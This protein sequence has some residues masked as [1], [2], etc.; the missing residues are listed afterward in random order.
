[1]KDFFSKLL[2]GMSIG[3]VVSLIPNALLGEVL[4][5]LI[6]H[7]PV[8]Q[9]IFDITVFVMSLLPVM[10]GVMV[11]ITFKL[12]SIQTASVG[13]AAMVGSGAIQK[14][15]DGLF[16]LNG[17]G[18]VINT[19]ITAA[20]TVLFVQLIGDR[21]KAYSILLMPT[22]SILVPGMIGY[23][24][25]P[26]VKSSTGL[27]GVAISNVTS[28]QPII[29]GAIISVVFCLII[30][31]PIS[32][33]GV[34]TVIMLSGIGSGAANLGIVA[35][36]VGLAIASYKANSLGTA[37]AHV[38]GSP[39]IQMRNFFMKPKIAFPMLIT[40]AILGALAGLL[41]IQGTPY[42]AGFGL[43]GLVGPLNYMK[44]AEGGWA[45]ENVAIML[46]TFFILPI[47]LNLGL[48]YIFS[49]KLKLI[50]AEDYKLHFD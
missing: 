43:S 47:V 42:S 45:V 10:I 39:K 24:I 34:A 12:T 41:N 30:L 15:A 28:L 7:F 33:V 3:I 9:H 49:K 17:I 11:G 8:L 29:M 16:A 22:L 23:L 21:L 35:A 46:S 26:F 13:I 18:I 1:M 40:A 5:L 50:K 31:S 44:L 20:L 48:I 27:L 32:T 36:G 4:K 25:L 19:G 2:T 14:T 37:L 38:L 6:P